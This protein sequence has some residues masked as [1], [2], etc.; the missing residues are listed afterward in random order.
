MTQTYA[1][2]SKN[3]KPASLVIRA[4][5]ITGPGL[6]LDL[7]AGS[8]RNVKFLLEQGFEVTA[9]D[10]DPVISECAAEVNNDKLHT[11]VTNFE[12]FDYGE[13]KYDL[14]VSINSLP[15]LPKDA[16]LRL[17]PKIKNALTDE[18]VLCIT[19]FGERDGWS[20]KKDVSFFSRSEVEGLF[21]DMH[22]IMFVEEDLEGDTI[23]GDPK[24]WHVF[25]LIAKR[26][27]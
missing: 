6:A 26:A 4:V 21:S 3:M 24:Y 25:K 5:K 13:R 27:E 10:K 1:E 12:D 19:L 8:L 9:V 18:G 23:Q 2:L 20:N 22:T 7:G 14:I 11:E 16:L 15:F 17:L